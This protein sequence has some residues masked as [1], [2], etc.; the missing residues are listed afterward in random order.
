MIAISDLLNGQMTSEAA[1]RDDFLLSRIISRW[2]E[3]VDKNVADNV[4]PV[5]MERDILFV[6]V[7]NSAFK[8]QLKFFAEEIIDA[9]NDAFE[10]EKLRIKEIRIAK[11]FQIADKPPEKIQSAQVT[12]SEVSMNTITLPDEEI[13][14]CE[15]A[16]AKIVDEN[17]RQIAFQTMAAYVRSQHLKLAN[18]WH[19]CAKC[20]VLCPPKD[21]FCVPCGIKEREAMVAELYRIFYDAPQMKT[22]EAQKLLLEQMPHMRGEC[23]PEVV[24]SARVSLI[25]RIA[26]KVR[27]GD[28]TSPDVL[29][30]VALEKRLPLEKL[31]P[32]IIKRTLLDLQFN[33]ADGAS[34][35]RYNA[36]KSSR[37]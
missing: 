24:E 13:K 16:V 11:G 15:D 34:L 10:Q 36:R 29:R 26:N 33:L 7:K 9:I 3:L 22:H 35:L 18:G 4:K 37:K 21:T 28:E 31:T 32:A 1:T 30:L 6:D 17:L 2:N 5:K 12:K 8:D 23:L 25:Q 20:E 27:F 19:K 14:A